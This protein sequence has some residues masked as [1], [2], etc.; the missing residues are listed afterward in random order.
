MGFIESEQDLIAMQIKLMQYI[1]A[2]VEE[3][4]AAEL[5]MFGAKVPKFSTIPQL[6]LHEAQELLRTKLNWKPGPDTTDLDPEGE[7]LL[8]QYFCETETQICSISHTIR[9]ACGPFYAMPT[10]DGLSHS[11]DLLYKGLEVTTGGQR[12]HK[13]EELIE[14]MRLR[15]T[16]SRKLHGLLAMFPLRNATTWRACNR[17]RAAHQATSGTGLQSSLPCYS[18]R[19]K[20]PDAITKW[21]ALVRV[22]I[23]PPVRDTQSGCSVSALISI[24]CHLKGQ[25]STEI[26]LRASR[27]SSQTG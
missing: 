10:A 15:G 22:L 5:E 23:N 20:S 8:C 18:T 14:S 17:S 16:G 21:S 7:R 27:R 13:A 9:V 3:T 1:F 6:K 11:F 25:Q 12:L 2:H 19:Q 4:C 26:R 24:Y